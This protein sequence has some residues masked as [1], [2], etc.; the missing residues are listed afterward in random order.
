MPTH[1]PFSPA[2]AVAPPASDEDVPQEALD[3]PETEENP[4]GDG[5]ATPPAPSQETPPQEPGPE[6]EEQRGL[7]VRAGTT[8]EVLDWVHE[9]GPDEVKARAQ[10]ALEVEQKSEEPRKGLSRDLEELLSDDSSA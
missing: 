3:G 5:A 6:Q 10:A 8:K 1:D 9:A 4:S 2:S 7:E